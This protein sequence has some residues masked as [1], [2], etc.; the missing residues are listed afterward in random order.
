MSNEQRAGQNKTVNLIRNGT[1]KRTSGCQL[2]NYPN[3]N[4]DSVGKVVAHHWKGYDYPFDVWFICHSCNTR[5][6]GKHDGVFNLEQ[7]SV[8]V[9]EF[10]RE[11]IYDVC[12]S[13][14]LTSRAELVA[15]AKRRRHDFLMRFGEGGEPLRFP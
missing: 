10:D 6:R 14:P 1:I 4:V 7:A 3:R 13:N 12:K 5:L 8:Y 9:S 15:E 11:W 2:C